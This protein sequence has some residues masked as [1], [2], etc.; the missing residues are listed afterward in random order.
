VPRLAGR[1]DLNLHSVML[2]TGH[3]PV[4]A[5]AAWI[6]IYVELLESQPTQ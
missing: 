2:R 1:G 3:R 5:L 4:E 6:R